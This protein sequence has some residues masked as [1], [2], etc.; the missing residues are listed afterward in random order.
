MKGIVNKTGYPVYL[1]ERL[2]PKICELQLEAKQ[3]GIKTVTNNCEL[4]VLCP[5]K[6]TGASFRVIHTQAEML[7]LKDVA[8]PL[9]NIS[10]RDNRR[11]G[12]RN[13]ISPAGLPMENKIIKSAKNF[14]GNFWRTN[15]QCIWLV[16]EKYSA[17]EFIDLP[18]LEK[19]RM[20]EKFSVFSRNLTSLRKNVKLLGINLSENKVSRCILAFSEA[21]YADDTLFF[22]ILGYQRFS[23]SNHKTEPSAAAL[24]V[25]QKFRYR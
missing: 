17:I 3:I 19:N 15:G 1:T 16:F 10:N 22:K 4:P 21:W 13:N 9:Q 23:A 11:P 6:E 5:R 14:W 18:G 2:P 25:D 20:K 24:S 12:R 8:H 7:K